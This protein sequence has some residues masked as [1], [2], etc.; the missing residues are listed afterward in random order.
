MLRI[1]TAIKN[2]LADSFILLKINIF[3]TNIINLFHLNH[4][5]QQY[6]S[7]GASDDLHDLAA[8]ILLFITKYITY[9]Y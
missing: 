6:Y 8:I 4:E 2:Y 1:S 9:F 7:I 5:Q 3:L